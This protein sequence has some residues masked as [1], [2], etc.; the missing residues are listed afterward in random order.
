MLAQRSQLER[1]RKEL[2]KEKE[3]ITRSEQQTILNKGGGSRAP[4]KIKF[5]MK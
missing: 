5:G 3:A 4:I 1:E 2:Q